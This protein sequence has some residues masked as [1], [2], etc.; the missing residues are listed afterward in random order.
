MQGYVGTTIRRKLIYDQFEGGLLGELSARG[1]TYR[2]ENPDIVVAEHVGGNYTHIKCLAAGET[3]LFANLD[4]G[5]GVPREVGP[6]T[7]TVSDLPRAV[8]VKTETV[9][10]SKPLALLGG[11]MI[12]PDA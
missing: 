10:V 2:A 11:V 4:Y 5:D 9:E 8:E 7:V 3:K 1:V 12:D 6:I